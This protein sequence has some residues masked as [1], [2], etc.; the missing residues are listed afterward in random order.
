M[1]TLYLVRVGW[2]KRME[3]SDP[4]RI[5]ESLARREAFLAALREGPKSK[6]ELEE[7][8]PVSRS[9][10]DRAVRDLE[11]AGLVERGDGSVRVTLSGRLVHETYEDFAAGIRGLV[12]AR[13]VVEP[14]PPGVDLDLS[15][16]KEAAVVGSS[17]HA[18][19]EPVE[20]LKAFLADASE[21]RGV[22]TAVLPEY[23][24]LYR[25]LIIEEET[26]VD[27]VVSSPVLETLIAEYRTPLE[28]SLATG[29][30]SLYE[31]MESPPFSTII[32]DDGDPEVALVVYGESGTSG[33]VR[34][35]DPDALDWARGW[36]DEWID[37]AGPIEVP[38]DLG[39]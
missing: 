3:P 29:R 1:P 23:V 7:A 39:R 9:T 35:D 2:V 13:R 26:T 30:L 36:I 38:G 19:H 28:R 6:R 22:A 11:S 32:A 24:D 16:F 33:F 4:A 21:I 34:N 31:T 17:R 8:L 10:V 12:R 14:V 27:L 18:P 15:V 37:R 20:A 25:Q 5:V